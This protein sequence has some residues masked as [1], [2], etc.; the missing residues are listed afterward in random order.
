MA[1]NTMKPWRLILLAWKLFNVAESLHGALPRS[2]PVSFPRLFVSTSYCTEL[3]T[4]LSGEEFETVRRLCE[5]ALLNPGQPSC[6]KALEDLGQLCSQRKPFDFS[7]DNH[8][9]EGCLLEKVPQ[10]IPTETTEKVFATIQEMQ[11]R[12]WL[13]TNPDSVDG[14]PSFHLNLVSSGKPVVENITSDGDAEPDFEHHVHELTQLVFPYIY[15]QLLPQIQQRLSTKDIRISDIFIRRY[16]DAI[17]DGQSRHGISAHYDVFSRVTCVIPLDDTAKDGRNGLYTTHK[18]LRA[19]RF[20]SLGTTTSNHRSLRRF[21]PLSCGDGVVHTWDVLHGV[22]VEPGVDRTSLIVWFT[23]GENDEE[24]T[25]PWLMDR[26]DLDTNHVAQ[27]VLASGLESSNGDR[28]AGK[29]HDLYL[30][31]AALGNLFAITRLGSLCENEELSGNEIERVMD[32]LESLEDSGSSLKDNFLSREPFSSLDLA[33]R[34][35]WQG[36]IRGN[37]IAQVALADE[38]MITA[39]APECADMDNHLVLASVLFA[40]AAQQGND[41][42]MESLHRIQHF[43]ASFRGINHPEEFDSLTTRSIAMSALAAFS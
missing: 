35:W 36:S 27:F 30:Q 37:P 6:F 38:L 10:L 20:S 12:G 3:K 18:T 1:S 32:L 23:S 5:K 9:P 11:E 34:L 14:L 22:D 17:I 39:T 41:H 24:G 21:F 28:S 29:I 8:C 26:N 25:V 33:K 2:R 13:S 19:D 43:E 31:S 15:D 7:Q 16:G 40:L 42:A 4:D